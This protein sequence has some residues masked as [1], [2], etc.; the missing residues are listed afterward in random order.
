MTD[1]GS[2]GTVKRQSSLSSMKN[3]KTIKPSF[4]LSKSENTVRTIGHLQG[5]LANVA[6][7]VS[8][9]HGL[10]IDLWLQWT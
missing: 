7:E 8:H 9:F 6:P 4:F 5:G 10:S 1:F 2:N 3:L